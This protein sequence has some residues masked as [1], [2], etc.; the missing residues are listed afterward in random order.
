ML[1]KKAKTALK[2]IMFKVD[3]SSQISNRFAAD[4]VK[5]QDF[6]E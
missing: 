6:R 5:F 4:L 2:A 3:P 1:G